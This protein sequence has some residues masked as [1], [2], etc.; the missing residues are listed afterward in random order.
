MKGVKVVISVS[1][2]SSDSNEPTETFTLSADSVYVDKEN[3]EVAKQM[4]ELLPD[5]TNELEN[6]FFSRFRDSGTY[7]NIGTLVYFVTDTE[8]DVYDVTVIT[9]DERGIVVKRE[10]LLISTDEVDDCNLSSIKLLENFRRQIGKDIARA[11]EKEL[12]ER[13]KL[14]VMLKFA[15]KLTDKFMELTD[16][17]KTNYETYVM[18]KD[19]L[20]VYSE[21][22]K[23]NIEKYKDKLK[24]VAKS[25]L[26]LNKL[27]L[28]FAELVKEEFVKLLHKEREKLLKEQEE[29]RKRLQK[30]ER[31]NEELKKRIRKLEERRSALSVIRAKFTELMNY[32]RE[33]LKKVTRF[34]RRDK[35][36]GGPS[37]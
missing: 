5:T 32:A 17:I 4:A 27:I 23:E 37:L 19:K 20:L 6:M 13:Y 9:N 10:N 7:D 11:Y 1:P 18:E 28:N 3:L 35:D 15:D 30:L 29:L 24:D 2:P 14:G 22:A 33:K 31:E 12:T 25:S 26:E 34:F 21:I 36:Y 8:I 16:T